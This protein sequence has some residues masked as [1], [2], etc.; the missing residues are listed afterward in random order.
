[1]KEDFDKNIK[2]SREL[3]LKAFHNNDQRIEFLEKGIE[4]EKYLDK[5]DPAIKKDI[6]DGINILIANARVTE[7]RKMQ[8][9]HFG[10]L[11]GKIRVLEGKQ[12]AHLLKDDEQL[13]NDFLQLLIIFFFRKDIETDNHSHDAIREVL[14]NKVKMIVVELRG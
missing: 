4:D 11:L 9:A 12:I 13:F 6:D 1:M 5:L 7:T 3:F 10:P 8:Q 2:L 14:Q